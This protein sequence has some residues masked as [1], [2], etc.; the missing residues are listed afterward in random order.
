MHDDELKAVPL[1]SGSRGGSSCAA[2]WLTARPAMFHTT[3]HDPVD[4]QTT[5]LSHGAACRMLPRPAPRVC[6]V[7][8]PPAS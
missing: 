8:A 7:C 1:P 3:L 2:P 6:L 4:D 5:V